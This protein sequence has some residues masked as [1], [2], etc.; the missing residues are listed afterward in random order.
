MTA[1]NSTPLVRRRGDG[2]AGQRRVGSQRGSCRCC[3]HLVDAETGAVDFVSGED[4]LLRRAA[5]RRAAAVR[6]QRPHAAG[7]RPLRDPR[8]VRLAGADDAEGLGGPGVLQRAARPRRAA[9]SDRPRRRSTSPARSLAAGHPFGATGGRIVATLAKLLAERGSGRGLISICAAGGQGV[10]ARFWSGAACS[11]RYQALT[12]SPLG[13]HD[14]KDRAAAS[15]R[16]RPLQARATRSS[17][18]R[19]CSAAPRAGALEEP[20]SVAL[21]SLEAA[22]VTGPGDR[23][24]SAERYAALVFDATGDR[25]SPRGCA[26][27][28]DFFH[29]V[30]RGLARSGRVVVLGT[31]PGGPG[32]RQAAIA[33]RALEGFTRSVAKELGAKGATAQLVYVAAR[34]RGRAR[35]DAALPALPQVGLRVGPGRSR[36]GAGDAAARRRTG[37]S[38][39][40][41]A[42][43]GHRRLA[44]HRRGDRRDAR[45][46][47]RRGRR[48]RH[49]R[50][51]ARISTAGRQP[52]RRH[53]RCS[54]TSPP[55]TRP[56][57]R[58]PPRT[59]ATAA[60]TS[61]STTPASPATRRSAA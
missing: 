60:S 11:D 35:V 49:R 51:R 17:T 41:A 10:V 44:R 2:P 19:S 18:V 38:R 6:A 20:L 31:P 14:Q 15:R 32:S 59:S 42:S 55:P 23:C 28:S 54:S 1:A 40:P 39:R 50:R 4:G 8:G 24:R 13:G 9:G 52:H 61:S 21:R 5:L 30:I 26:R 34:R 12:N 3:A 46:R 56:D 36:V 16:A 7:L 22:V 45:P 57:A 27:C 58:R 33:Q 53:P 48:P 37:S 29:P 47:R 43:R 25:R